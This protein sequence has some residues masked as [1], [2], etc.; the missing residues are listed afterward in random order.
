VAAKRL[1]LISAGLVFVLVLAVAC[2]LPISTP[3]PTATVTLPPTPTPTPTPTPPALSAQ[4]I[5]EAATKAMEE[6]GSY[7]FDLTMQMNA[8]TVDGSLTMKIPMALA[9]DVREPGR[10]KATMK[11]ELLGQS[12][13]MDMIIIG[14]TTYYREA[15]T[16]EWQAAP[17]ESGSRPAPSG[18]GMA[19]LEE[20]KD[21]TFVGEEMLAGSPVYHVAGTAPY[22]LSFVETL[23]KVEGD[24]QVDYWIN[25]ENNCPVKELIQGDVAA[26]G[27]IE[28]TIAISATML[29]SDYGQAVEIEAPRVVGDEPVPARPGTLPALLS[30][31][32][33]AHLDRGFAGLTGDRP[34]LAAAHFGRAVKLQPDLSDIPLLYRGLAFLLL[35]QGDAAAQEFTR[36]I[37]L[38]PDRPDAYLLRALSADMQ[39]WKDEQCSDVTRAAELNPDL[40][41]AR[42]LQALCHCLTAADRTKR[43]VEAI[44]LLAEARALDAAT[45]DPYYAAAAYSCLVTLSESGAKAQIEPWLTKIDAGLEEYPDLPASHFVHAMALLYLRREDAIQDHVEAWIDLYHYLDLADCPVGSLLRLGF[46]R[47]DPLHAVREIL[48]QETCS[49]AEERL[50]SVASEIYRST[51][52][53]LAAKD[54]VF[55]ARYEEFRRLSTDYMAV[56]MERV[57]AATRY[58]PVQ[59]VAFSAGGDEVATLGDGGRLLRVMTIEGDP[60]LDDTL[61]E[62]SS[63]VHAAALSLDGTRIVLAESGLH[64]TTWDVETGE[65]LLSATLK[66]DL[67]AVA[68]S[69]DGR[70]ILAGNQNNRVYLLDAETGAKT[71]TL[72]VPLPNRMTA[73]DSVAISP[74][75]S[76]IAV[77]I[78]GGAHVM[79]AATGAELWAVQDPCAGKPTCVSTDAIH[80]VAISPDGTRL[81]GSGWNNDAVRIWDLATGALLFTLPGHGP[82]GCGPLAFSPD[83]QRIATGANDGAVRVWLLS[84]DSAQ[85]QAWMGHQGRSP[86]SETSFRVWA[87]AFSPDGTQLVTGGQDG[88]T[89]LWDAQTGEEL[90]VI[91]MAPPGSGPDP[92]LDDRAQ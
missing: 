78:Y 16:G 76:R 28:L 46:D 77:A 54:A 39:L 64:L 83:G 10:M 15:T 22:P 31:S 72:D 62:T 14:D 73:I 32:M 47:S 81:A 3:T 20:I 57:N 23:G 44:D 2:R 30:D 65:Q 37:E 61:S 8:A 21:A 66:D 48:L 58:S 6:A 25:R 69:P 51:A 56:A 74:D 68:F 1:A 91:P 67:N 17:T 33:T 5:L 43:G 82:G 92:S 41:E 18:P 27:E 55:K 45:A 50:A 34:G 19:D 88:M 60:I 40:V 63:P 4:E 70:L 80:H 75:G 84:P 52:E 87:V 89:R 11:M 36:L 59:A 85:L 12:L 29:F 38:D 35:G 86:R 49:T 42:T 79:D 9:G 24:I 7:H 71:G 53:D 26:S 13:D 90:L